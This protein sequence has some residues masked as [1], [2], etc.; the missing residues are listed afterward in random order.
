MNT[1]SARQRAWNDH[2]H[3]FRE[4]LS[5]LKGTHMLRFGGTLERSGV[6]FWRNDGNVTLTMRQGVAK[7]PRNP[8][9]SRCSRNLLHL[10]PFP[11]AYT[12]G[13]GC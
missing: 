2:R 3:G 1:Y 12:T 5:W 10:L 11:F 7:V 4:N 6:L 9:Q 8:R 13:G